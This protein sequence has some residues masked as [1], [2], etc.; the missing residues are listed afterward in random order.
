MSRPHISTAAHTQRWLEW[1]QREHPGIHEQLT[2][3]NPQS[4]VVGLS[5]GADSLALVHAAIRAGLDVEAVVVDHQLQVGSAHVA[6]RAAQQAETLGARSRV[7][8]VN[9]AETGEG[10]ARAARYQALGQVAEGRGVLVAHTASDDAEGFLLALA[11]GSGTDSLAGMHALTT[12]HPAVHSGAGWV[13]RPLLHATR[14]DTERTCHHAELDF[15]VDPHN[16]SA[17]YLRSRIRTKLLP[18]MRAI[19]GE[20]VVDNLAVSSRLLRDDATALV[21][22][23]RHQLQAMEDQR[24]GERLASDKNDQPAPLDCRTIATELAA[25]RRRIYRAWLG[26]H[27]GPLT[28]AH[29]EAIDALVIAWRG[30]GPVSVPWP[31]HWPTMNPA[32]RT[33]HR[34]VVRRQNRQLFL[35]VIARHKET[36]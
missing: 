34:L 20:A 29:M 3:S 31:T 28:N 33:T 12:E 36:Q 16:E 22:L 24:G 26:E 1:V 35:D 23:A 19:L 8:T 27:V 15:W 30:Q 4:V 6:A 32:R 10:P 18:Q 14:A 11:R 5:G 17:D 2:G 25:V 7:V 9:I 13:G 21:Q